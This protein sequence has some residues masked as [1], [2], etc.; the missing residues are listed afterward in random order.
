MLEI[1]LYFAEAGLRTEVQGTKS[2][3]LTRW[4]RSCRK[5]RVMEGRSEGR[6]AEGVMGRGVG[7][8]DGQVN[9]TWLLHS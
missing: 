2:R 8:S 9:V 5:V 1:I 4:M 7:C 6:P 3:A